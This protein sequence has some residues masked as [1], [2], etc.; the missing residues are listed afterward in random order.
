MAVCPS[1]HRHPV[2]APGNAGKHLADSQRAVP[3]R[4][5][6]NDIRG[7]FSIPRADVHAG[8]CGRNGC[9]GLPGLD[10]QAE[11]PGARS[12]AVRL[13]QGKD[14]RKLGRTKPV[15]SHGRGPLHRAGFL[16]PL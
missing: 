8:L 16:Q 10:R 12:G 3:D 5:V 9:H 13:C 1:G 14:Y 11:D 7:V 6:R 2:H 15:F 4:R